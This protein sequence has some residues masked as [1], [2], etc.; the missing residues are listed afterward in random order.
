M[1][2]FLNQLSPGVAVILALIVLRLMVAAPVMADDDDFFE[3]EWGNDEL[4]LDLPANNLKI[5]D[6]LEP[7]NRVFFSFNDK[8]MESGPCQLRC[9]KSSHVGT[10]EQP[11]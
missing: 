3:D 1:R 6:P 5:A 9:K 10:A 4:V 8:M 11:G 7:L 2:K